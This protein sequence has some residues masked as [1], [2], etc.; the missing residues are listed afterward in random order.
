MQL[1]P[2]SKKQETITLKTYT[3]AAETRVDI[4]KTESTEIKALRTVKGVT[5]QNQIYIG[6][7]KIPVSRSSCDEK[8]R[9]K[10]IGISSLT[11]WIELQKDEGRQTITHKTSKPSIKTM[12]EE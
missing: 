8:R 6:T 5:L 3:H 2:K 11:E 9:N 7:I 1:K 10:S 4:S 12:N